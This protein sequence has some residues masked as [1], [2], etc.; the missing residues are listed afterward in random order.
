VLF[1]EMFNVNVKGLLM[2]TKAALKVMGHGR[3]HHRIGSHALKVHHVC[4][5][6]R[7]ASSPRGR[8]RLQRSSSPVESTCF[9]CL[10]A[11]HLSQS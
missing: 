3:E 4:D 6:F 11:P 5:R 2:V 1:D 9:R 10:I 7:S 8:E